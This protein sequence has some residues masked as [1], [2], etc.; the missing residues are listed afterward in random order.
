MES[1]S[2]N[3]MVGRTIPTEKIGLIPTSAKWL[4]G[5]A[6]GVWFDIQKKNDQYQI[7]RYSLDG[8]LDC[9]RLFTLKNKEVF[10]E[11]SPFEIAHTSHC[12]LVRAIQND[13][14]FVF[15]Y[16]GK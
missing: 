5:E 14:L 7:K 9:D 3:I 1:N 2:D 10:N 12:A 11:K 16:L 13:I 6:G 4:S 8:K 15:E